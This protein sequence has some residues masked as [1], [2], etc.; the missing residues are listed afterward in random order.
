MSLEGKIRLERLKR[1][2]ALNL[3]DY[4]NYSNCKLDSV[5]LRSK[6]VSLGLDFKNEA[7][8]F[9]DIA[10][11]FM[12]TDLSSKNEPKNNIQLD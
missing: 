9:I 4:R 1:S 7:I 12:T 8:Y 3:S 11:L 10:G 5:I 6:E 2:I